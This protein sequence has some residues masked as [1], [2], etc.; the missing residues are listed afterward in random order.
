L[1]Y[2]LQAAVDF[3]TDPTKPSP[4]R[5]IEFFTFLVAIH[6]CGPTA[7]ITGSGKF[8]PGNSLVVIVSRK[9]IKDARLLAAMKFLERMEAD[10]MEANPKRRPRLQRMAKLPDYAL[11]YDKVILKNGGWYKLRYTTG[12]RDLE[13]EIRGWKKHARNVARIIEFSTRFKPRPDKP[14]Q[15]GGPTMA[16]DIIT[17]DAIRKYFGTTLK[18][19]QLYPAWQRAKSVAPFLYLLYVRKYPYYL[20]LIAGKELPRRLVDKVS[21]RERLIDFLRAYNSVVQQLRPRNYHYTELKLP[22]GETHGQPL[23]FEAFSA[24]DPNQSV[25]LDEIFSYGK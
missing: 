7:P 4:L 19:T 10:W 2:D 25:V 12:L 24:S 16:I 18:S 13:D 20:K 3:I 11:I 17:H 22:D 23:I 14:K 21:D 5:A 9:L 15:T 1:K 8:E 6:A